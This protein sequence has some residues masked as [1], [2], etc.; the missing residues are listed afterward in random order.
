MVVPWLAA[1]I[2]TAMMFLP[3]TK[4]SALRPTLMSQAKRL[5]TPTSLAAARACRPADLDVPEL[6]S[7]GEAD[8]FGE[9]H[10]AVLSAG[11]TDGDGN[12]GAVAGR[13]AGQPFFEVGQGIAVEFV[14]FRLRLEVLDD[15]LVEAAEI[16]QV[17]LPVGIR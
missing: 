7:Q 14:D 2:I 9:V 15:R 8:A 11:A 10:R 12:V 13:E 4:L 1:S 17:G 3:L 5:A 16:A 6:G